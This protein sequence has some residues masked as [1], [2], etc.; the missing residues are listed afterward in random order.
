M[1]TDDEQLFLCLIRT[2]NCDKNEDDFFLSTTR[3][4]D[5][6]W[7]WTIMINEDQELW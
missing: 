2:K 1:M 5:D 4:E 6:K 3:Y 7:W